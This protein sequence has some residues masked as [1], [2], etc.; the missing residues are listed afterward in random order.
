MTEDSQVPAATRAL[1]L[2][3]VLGTKP[4]PVPAASLAREAGLPRSTTYHLLGALIRAGFVVHLPEEKRYGLGLAVYEL[5]VGY[6]RQDPLTR[7]A[8]PL[9]D[10]LAA[11]VGADGPVTAHLSVL[12]GR[13]S[14]YLLKSSSTPAATVLADVGVRLPAHLTATGR[15]VLAHLPAAQVRTLFPDRAAFV[16]RTGRGPTSPAQLRE[17]LAAERRQG[18]ATEDGQVATD[19]ASVA[20]PVLD[21]TAHPVAGIG[22]TFRAASRPADQW[23]ALAERAHTAALALTHRLHG[24]PLAPHS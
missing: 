17:L 12:H 7:L 16:D 5:G 23:Q 22:V 2:L 6:L 24:T 18:W 20:V 9:V 10:Q 19:L 4:G 21:H 8:R 13:D 11:D 3:R 15:A 1:T 14:L